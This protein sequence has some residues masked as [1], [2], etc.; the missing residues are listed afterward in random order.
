LENAIRRTRRLHQ[1]NSLR[2]DY[3]SCRL[4]RR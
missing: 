4:I 3:S 2:R 1:T